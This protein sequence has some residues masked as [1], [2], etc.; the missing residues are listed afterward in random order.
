MLARLGGN[1][2]WFLVSCLKKL[3]CLM[4]VVGLFMSFLVRVI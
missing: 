2:V 3:V 1:D 4:V